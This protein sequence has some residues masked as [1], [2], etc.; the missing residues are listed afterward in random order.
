[1]KYLTVDM[2]MFK[3]F[4]FDGFEEHIYLLQFT[5]DT[6]IIGKKELGECENSKSHAKV[7]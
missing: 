1:M 6:M 4:S 5:D 2:S 7:V 3:G